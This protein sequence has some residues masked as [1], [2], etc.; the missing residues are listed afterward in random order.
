M[1]D[2][3]QVKKFKGKNGKIYIHTQRHKCNS[4]MVHLDIYEKSRGKLTEKE[5]QIFNA[6]F[7]MGYKDSNNRRRLLEDYKGFIT[8]ILKGLEDDLIIDKIGESG[9]KDEKEVVE[10]IKKYTLL[11]IKK[12]AQA[13]NLLESKKK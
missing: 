12:K 13:L 3:N 5:R 11:K 2:P 1:T 7:N 6:S 9:Y 8:K 4:R 10:A